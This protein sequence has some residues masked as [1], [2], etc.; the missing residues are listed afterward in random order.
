MKR[1]HARY[2]NL[3]WMKLSEIARYWAAKELTRIEPAG[4]EM[5]FHAPFAAKDFT[6]KVKVESAAP[7]LAI[8]AYAAYRTPPGWKAELGSRPAGRSRHALICPKGHRFWRFESEHHG[9]S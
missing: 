4:W 1:L 7:G 5:R 8:H 2:D 3:I 6:V 9:G